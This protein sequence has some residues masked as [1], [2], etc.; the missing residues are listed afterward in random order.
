MCLQVS[1]SRIARS[2]SLTPGKGRSPPQKLMAAHKKLIKWGSHQK[3]GGE[4]MVAKW[5]TKDDS[6]LP[7]GIISAKCW[8]MSRLPLLAL[9]SQELPR[10]QNRGSP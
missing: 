7:I 8:S 3:E 2:L 5:E 10:T 6:N 1:E 9:T 4:R